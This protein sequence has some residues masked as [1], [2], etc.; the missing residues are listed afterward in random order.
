M[1]SSRRAVAF[2]VGLCL[3]ARLSPADEKSINPK[4]QEI[5]EQISEARI[6]AILEKLEGFGTRNTMSTQDDPVRGVG[7]A[8]TWILDEFKTVSYTHLTLPTNREV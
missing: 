1:T 6:K 2:A 8:R 5:L 4:I 3:T 7:A